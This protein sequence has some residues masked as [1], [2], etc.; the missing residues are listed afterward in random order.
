M[1]FQFPL[2]ERA[3]ILNFSLY[4]RA[5]ELDIAFDKDVFC[6]AGANG[7]GKSTFL[8]ILNY[9]LTG[10]VIDPTK[11][12]GATVATAKYYSVNKP[13]A[14]SYFDGRIDEAD[15]ERAK[16]ELTFTIG[17]VR[18]VVARSFFEAEEIS[19][20]SRIVD[21][22][23]TIQ[24][25]FPPSELFR[26]YCD[27][28][29]EDIGLASFDQYVFLQH[30]ILSFDERH[31]LL[32]WDA[33]IMETA[34]FLFFG[35]DVNEAQTANNL[36]KR[37]NQLG[38]N[39]RNFVY[40]KNRTANEAQELRGRIGD[41]RQE[42]SSKGFDLEAYQQKLAERESGFERIQHIDQDIK[43]TELNIAD[44]S[45]R[46]VDAQSQYD[47][48]F[49]STMDAPLRLDTDLE[50]AELLVQLRN[51]L[52]HGK[53][54]DTQL[55]TI[56]EH[57]RKRYCQPQVPFASQNIV[58]LT[59]IDTRISELKRHVGEQQSKKQ[60]LQG[61]LQEARTSLLAI[62]STIS[63]IEK[64]QGEEVARLRSTASNDLTGLIDSY[65][66]QIA[67]R[68]KEILDLRAEQ[69]QVT[70][71]LSKLEKRLRKSFALAEESFV[72]VFQRYVQNFLG[73]DVTVRLQSTA[74]STGLVLSMSQ[75]E[76][77]STYQLSES[78]RYFIDIGLRMA[79]IEFGCKSVTL[80][81]DTPE[82]SL[83]IAYESKAGQMFA[84]Y[85]EPN[86]RL[87]LTANINTSQLLVQ[88]AE[89]CGG[90][91]MT[92]SRMTEWSYLTEV[93]LQ[94]EEKIR[95]AFSDIEVHLKS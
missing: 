42:L 15:R 18:Y 23:E 63:E 21:G 8:N 61:E 30:F 67:K 79:L 78:Q 51:E 77:T 9:G 27:H 43:Q 5:S 58:R 37:I 39:I 31:S 34:L 41:L 26:L 90:T 92:L 87:I 6:L 82:G 70:S 4:K 65:N 13:F 7:L 48:E 46:L 32:F 38:S 72:P 68:E 93:Q 53:S 60:R 50:L 3:K 83:D 69:E 10:V 17:P 88:L 11:S 29:T 24:E 55:Q 1:K 94:E 80:L 25:S 91:G 86:R 12:F 95:Q 62:E 66:D 28:V 84:A 64:T 20:F 36:R 57:V 54:G 2:L 52:R 45:I 56:R 14:A 22:R 16:V 35:L 49:S 19:A 74:K 33:S 44:Y 85:S 81:I 71:E 59:E 73:M 89:R 47:R 40:Q 76:R 75:S